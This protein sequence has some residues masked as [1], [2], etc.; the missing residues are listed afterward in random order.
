MVPYSIKEQNVYHTKRVE[1]KACLIPS[2]RH[3]RV[4]IIQS[5]FSGT[6]AGTNLEIEGAAAGTNTGQMI[7]ILR[8]NTE[9][10][11]HI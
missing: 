10:K 1:S 4:I 11:M 6:K 2:C 3:L 8:G 5:V 7:H 9:N